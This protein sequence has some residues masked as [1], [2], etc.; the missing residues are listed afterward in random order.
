M[1][2]GIGML[3]I[4][5]MAALRQ[6]EITK[7]AVEPIAQFGNQVGKLAAQ[8]PMYAPIIPTGKGMTSAVGI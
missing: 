6:S 2:F 7:A 8:A 3:W 1:L 5:V 4:A